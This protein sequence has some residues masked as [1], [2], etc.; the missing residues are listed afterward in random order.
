MVDGDT[1]VISIGKADRDAT[2]RFLNFPTDLVERADPGLESSDFDASLNSY[3]EEHDFPVA[4]IS[5]ALKRLLFK[6]ACFYLRKKKALPEMLEM[7]KS[8]DWKAREKLLLRLFRKEI[9]KVQ[10][11]LSQLADRHE[12]L[13]KEV[14]LWTSRQ[15]EIVMDTLSFA[16]IV[17]HYESNAVRIMAKPPVDSQF[18]WDVREAL[19]SRMRHS[20]IAD[21]EVIVAGCAAAAHI[22]S[23]KD[24]AADIVSRIP[25]R[26]SRATKTFDKQLENARRSRTRLFALPP[27]KKPPPWGL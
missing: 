10:R 7:V 23:A 19:K 22:F 3:L 6:M 27:Q 25:M 14:V 24:D 17:Q 16:Y 5:K 20:K 11:K 12:Q 2:S 1:L 13:S 18:I 15:L 21:I 4:K 26:I 8:R 9:P